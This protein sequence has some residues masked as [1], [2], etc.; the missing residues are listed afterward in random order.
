MAWVAVYQVGV[1]RGGGGG[2]WSSVVTG[3]G[4][5]GVEGDEGGW[6]EG[7]RRGAAGGGVAPLVWL[8]QFEAC[9]CLFKAEVWDLILI[10]S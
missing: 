2:R 1:A 6:A 4:V 8:K 10:L 5:R 7:L 3:G 9:E